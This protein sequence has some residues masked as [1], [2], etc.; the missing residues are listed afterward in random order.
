M[1][2]HTF[3]LLRSLINPGRYWRAVSHLAQ[4][5]HCALPFALL[6]SPPSSA[7]LPAPQ[8]A[9]R[10]WSLQWEIA[11]QRHV[12]QFARNFEEIPS[13]P[14][15]TATKA[16]SE[17]QCSQGKTRKGG[18]DTFSIGLYPIAQSDGKEGILRHAAEYNPL[19]LR[20]VSCF[21][22]IHRGKGR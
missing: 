19:A 13:L 16:R 12:R 15:Q 11:N 21:T 6:V 2:G 4:S 7:S 1:K 10:Q 18:K 3:Y 22:Q 5:S 14:E 20:K 8:A 9:L 17:L